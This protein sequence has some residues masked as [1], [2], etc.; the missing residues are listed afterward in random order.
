[1]YNLSSADAGKFV[2]MTIEMTEKIKSLGKN[3][4]SDC[5]KDGANDNR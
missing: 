3:P 1:M 4:L 5:R 2:E